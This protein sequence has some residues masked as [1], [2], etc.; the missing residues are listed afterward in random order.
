M[1]SIQAADLLTPTAKGLRL[2]A[3]LEINEL[4][5]QRLNAGK[6]VVHLGFG[7]A[8]FP[9][10]KDVLQA[11]REASS[12]TSYLPVAGLP[13]LREVSNIFQ[14]ILPLYACVYLR[15][16]SLLRGSK[17]AVWAVSSSQTKLSSPQD[18]SLFSSPSS[19]FYRAMCSYHGPRGSAMSRR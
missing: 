14:T 4:V 11:H 19:T 3:T 5:K 10:Q 2:S 6:R 18:P 7:E 15:L 1:A 9:M 12:D 8:T 13:A 17:H 16:Y